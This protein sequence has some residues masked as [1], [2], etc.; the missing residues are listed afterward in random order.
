MRRPALWALS[1]LLS[2]SSL[3]APFLHVAFTGA[4]ASS[5]PASSSAGTAYGLVQSKFAAFSEAPPAWCRRRPGDTE[6]LG[7]R[8]R[9][10]DPGPRMKAVSTFQHLG[11]SLWESDV[12]LSDAPLSPAAQQT[13]N[14]LQLLHNPGQITVVGQTASS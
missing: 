12:A 3:A 13:V 14:D 11:G 6:R 5:L 4:D 2:S 10:G 7:V 1:A 8:C 9:R